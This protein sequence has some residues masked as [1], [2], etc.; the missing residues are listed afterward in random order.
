M[1]IT[2]D[3]DPN[4]DSR[5][6]CLNIISKK[7][8]EEDTDE[9][10]IIKYKNDDYAI[11]EILKLEGEKAAIK[12]N[13]EDEKLVLKA[14]PITLLKSESYTYS[15]VMVFKRIWKEYCLIKVN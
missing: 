15:Y 12:N 2:F 4:N 1:T 5:Y 14:K 10:F 6:I 9:Y 13:K 7:W 11:Q 3:D 8:I